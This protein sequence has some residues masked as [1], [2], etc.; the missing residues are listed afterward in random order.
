MLAMLCLVATLGTVQQPVTLQLA[1]GGKS[2]YAI[3]IPQNA[4]PS[5][6]RAAEELQRFLQQITDARLPIVTDEPASLSQVRKAIAL[7]DNRLLRESGVQV[8]WKALGDEGFT[9]I[10]QPP[11]LF[12]AGSPKR[13]TMYGVY[14][15][16]ED[17]I[18]CRWYSSKVSFI[19]QKRNLTVKI[20]PRTELPA[21]EYRE[22]YFTDAWDKHWAARNRVN[23]TFPRLDEST[24]GKV[25]YGP[26]VHTFYA[27]VPPEKYAKEHPEYYSLVKGVRD[28]QRGQLCLT[29]PDVLRIA[30]ETVKRWI[31]EQP[32]ATIFSVSQNDW[33]NPCEC[34]G[35]RRI[36]EE[37]GSESGPVLRFVNA[38]AEEIEKEYPDKLIDTLAYWYTEDPP[39]NVRP[40]R[41]VRVRLAPIGAC[42]AHP[43]GTCQQN[44]KQYENL[45][46]WARITDQLYIWHYTTNFAHYLM[47]FPN[48]D[49]L[50]RSLAI[51][52]DNGVKG[53]FYQGNYSPGGGGEFNELRAWVLAKLMWNP[54]KDFWALVD[55]FLRGYYGKAAP[56]IRR[57]IDLMHQPVR[58]GKTD[59]EDRRAHVHIFDPPTAPYLRPELL[60][61]AQKLFDSA[62]KAVRNETEVLARVQHARLWVEY[63]QLAQRMN[64][65]Q[66]VGDQYVMGRDPETLRLRDT[67]LEKIR[68]FGITNVE[69]W[70]PVQKFIDRIAALD[71]Q[72]YPVVTLQNGALRVDIVP[73]LG[74]RI[75]RILQTEKERNILTEAGSTPEAPAD[76][77]YEEYAT[78]EYRSTGWRDAFTVKASSPTQVLLELKLPNGLE[79]LRTI[80]LIGDGPQLVVAS[81]YRN[82]GQ[83]PL[84]V[85]PRSHPEFA[86]GEGARYTWRSVGGARG[87]QAVADFGYMELQRENLPDGEVTLQ[88]RGMPTLRLRFSHKEVEQVYLNWYA[89]AR[90]ANIELF[91]PEKELKPGE[92]VTLRWEMVVR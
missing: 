8:D 83:S 88:A 4:S 63:T 80:S 76:G 68:R 23:G 5:Q 50:A 61:Q 84:R 69:E 47:P 51:Y 19:P 49:E 48:F 24:G 52:R 79:I 10:P 18:G 15:F 30:T 43:F 44:M 57:Y 36:V 1:S 91:L 11:H 54:D 85:S 3:V 65:W 33:T 60:Q 12:I 35:C 62:E 55:D 74:G 78:R 75:V 46:A 53:V 38:L 73:A 20:A 89:P 71:K 86:Y 2:D 40:R 82:G 56:Y 90:R 92:S 28:T 14:G 58:E 13:G 9:I 22:P 45:R 26:F 87:E 17:D 70:N 27:L 59:T 66:V 21:F 72:S 16:L 77:G 31:R 64:K 25:S 42:F 81:T 41:N 7:G 67:V 32:Q 37:E 6:R 34:E 29:N 39:K